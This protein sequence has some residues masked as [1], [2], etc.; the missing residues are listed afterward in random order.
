MVLNFKFQ[1]IA[2]KILIQ[3][4]KDLKEQKSKNLGLDLDKL[5]PLPPCEETVRRQPPIRKRDLI[6]HQIRQYLP[7]PPELR[8]K[9]LLFISHAIYGVSV[10]IAQK[11]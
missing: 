1:L 9:F 6:R 5:S 4:H 8:N 2:F 7:Q 11:D 10:I 3:D